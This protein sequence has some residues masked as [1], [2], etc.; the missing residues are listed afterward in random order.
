MVLAEQTQTPSSSSVAC[1]AAGAMSRKRPESRVSSTINLSSGLKA[2][3][4]VGLGEGSAGHSV[5]R[6]VL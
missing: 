2:R 3:A 4:G 6:I 1:T 5:T